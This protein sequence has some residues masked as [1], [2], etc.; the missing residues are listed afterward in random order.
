MTGS[1]Q[2]N[3]DMD[4]GGEKRH[5]NLCWDGDQDEKIR[6]RRAYEALFDDCCKEKR[7]G[8]A[9]AA[10]GA[11]EYAAKAGF[12]NNDDPILPFVTC[13]ALVLIEHEDPRGYAEI[14]DRILV[15]NIKLDD[16]KTI[17]EFCDGAPVH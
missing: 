17:L 9:E 11:I 1:L 3:I 5:V 7:C 12:A 10:I 13:A 15:C 2:V 8:L 16:E 6:L 14:G 4:V